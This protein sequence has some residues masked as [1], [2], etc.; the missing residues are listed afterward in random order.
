MLDE[1]F[2]STLVATQGKGDYRYSSALK[3]FLKDLNYADEWWENKKKWSDRLTRLDSMGLAFRWRRWCCSQT[4]SAPYRFSAGT[5]LCNAAPDEQFKYIY[6]QYL[7]P[8]TYIYVHWNSEN[9]AYIST[10]FSGDPMRPGP[11]P[12]QLET[13]AGPVLVTEGGWWEHALVWGWHRHD[14]LCASLH[15][16]M[17]QS[18]VL[19]VVANILLV[20]SL[21]FSLLFIYTCHSQ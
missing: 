17:S 7:P 6:Q 11:N 8:R 2:L 21:S 1:M 9:D 3:M 10:I 14:H 19:S 20:L 4:S 12:E 15:R 5:K 13:R 16:S 18:L